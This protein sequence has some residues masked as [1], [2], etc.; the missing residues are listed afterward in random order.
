MIEVVYEKEKQKAEG[1]ECFFRIPNNIRQIGE[2]NGTQKIYIE[3]YAYTYLCRISSENSSIG[4]AAILLGQSNWKEGV[5][6]LFIKS[7]VALPEMEITEEHLTF[8]REI[9]NHVYEKNKEFFP[10]QEV[11]GWFLSIPGCSMELHDVI[12]RT[13]L[14]HFGGNDKVL[15]V[16]E[17]LEKEEA[18]YRYEEGK[19]SRQNGFYVYYEKNEA[20]QNFLVSQNEKSEKK[21]EQ[22][23]DQAVK[24]FR[25]KI[26]DKT[27]E[28]K[29][30][31]K[32]SLMKTASVC[33]GALLLAVSA[34]Y[35]KDHN[36]MQELNENIQ[37]EPVNEKITE[38][39]SNEKDTEE[40]ENE[41]KVT[42]EMKE[43][44]R[45]ETREEQ[46]ISEPVSG[47]THQSYI[48]QRGDTLTGISRRYYGDASKI[49]EICEL[50]HLSVEEFIFPGQKILLP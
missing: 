18:F 20:M 5:S 19:L 12:C 9:W 25:K 39:L 4:R 6:Y 15:M 46:A 33:M 22:V 38:E 34:I 14:N 48:I 50:N 10:E 41:E 27:E 45:E 29:Q 42:E 2:I 44:T 8:T 13:H 28:K 1:N 40:I 47:E 16:M 43:E 32:S 31:K 17:P 49:R 26:E 35:L 37:K 36:A 21:S 7:A 11:V 3:D 24:N 23:E 30:K